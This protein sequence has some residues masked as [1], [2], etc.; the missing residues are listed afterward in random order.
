MYAIAAANANE[1]WKEAF[2]FLCD[3]AKDGFIAESRDGDVVGEI[4]NA[5][6]CIKDPTRNIV[7]NPIRHLPM[8]YAVGELMWYLSGSNMTDD[9]AK[10]SPVWRNLSDDGVHA[11]SAYGYRIFEKYGFDQMQYVIDTLTRDPLSR[12]A[13]IHIKDPVDYG[14]HPTKDVPCTVCLQFLIRHN[15]LHMTVYMRSN[16]IWM[17]LPYDVFSF[18]CIQILLAFKLGVDIG[19]YTHHAASLHLYKRDYETALKNMQE[20][21]QE[22]SQ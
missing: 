6:I 4:L 10:F 1:A 20:L 3:Q 14:E 2:E 22:K 12:Q 21:P 19:T 16:D 5:V 15:K 11:N 9:I 7:S 17:G 18:T 13:V 8:R